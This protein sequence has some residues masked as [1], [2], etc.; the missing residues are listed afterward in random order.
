M[1]DRR[2]EWTL[3]I[4]VGRKRPSNTDVRAWIAEICETRLQKPA[5][6]WRV[7]TWEYVP[8]SHGYLV[9]LVR[10]DPENPIKAAFRPR[11]FRFAGKRKS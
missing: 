1:S 2:K 3:F 8:H 10:R 7:A 4:G 6:L 11:L 5:A 9:K